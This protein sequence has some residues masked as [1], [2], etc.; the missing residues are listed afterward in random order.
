MRGVMARSNPAEKKGDNRNHEQV[1]QLGADELLGVVGPLVEHAAHEA[2]FGEQAG[3]NRQQKR[4]AEHAK[5]PSSRLDC[6]EEEPE[7]PAANPGR[8][9]A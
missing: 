8:L 4:K 6:A 1:G 7:C 9:P 3:S 5:S 2:A